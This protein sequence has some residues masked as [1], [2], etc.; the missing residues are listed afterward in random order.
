MQCKP[1]KVQLFSDFF[2]DLV[3]GNKLFLLKLSLTNIPNISSYTER[4]R[5]QYPQNLLKDN[6]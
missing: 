2:F 5:I 4:K 3:K 1:E 6:I